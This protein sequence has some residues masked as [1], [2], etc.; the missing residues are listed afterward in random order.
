MPDFREYVRRNLPPLGLP[1]EREAEIVEE[2]ALEFEENFR[3]ATHSGLSPEEAFR[4]VVQRARPWSGLANELRLAFNAPRSKPERSTRT[5]FGGMMRDLRYG[6]RQLRKAPSFAI[7]TMLTLA[8]G[9]GANTAIFSLLDVVML[10]NLPVRDPQQLVLFGAGQARGGNDALPGGSTTLFS[11]PFFREFRR[12][13]QVFS[14]VAA[15]H[16]ILFEVHGRVGGSAGFEKTNVELVSGSYFHT[17]GV[18]SILGRVLTDADDQTP[19]AHPVAV[20]S[21][22]WWRQRFAGDPSILRRTI[23]VGP[24]IYTI[25]GVA[26][27][28]FFGMILEESPD[29]WIPLAMEKEISPGWNGL[30]QNLFQSLHI[31]ARRKPAVGMAQAGANSNL[32]F[33]QILREYA[34]PQP[35][36]SDLQ[37]IGRARIDLTSAA[38]GFSVLRAQFSRPLEI[39]MAVVALVLLIACANVAN[40]LLARG[41]ARYREIAVRLAMG[42][43]RS[44]LI[45]QLLVE[46]GLLGLAGA[47]LGILIAWGG[48]QLL[49]A[50]SPIR[51]APDARILAFTLALT[52][53]TVLLFGTFPA[54]RSTG[55]DLAPSLKEGRGVLSSPLR[56]RFSPSL[57]VGQVALSLVLLAG[58]GL[59]LR[60]FINLM[61]V[62]TGFDKRNLLQISI[63]PAAAGY[64]LDARLE[65][66]MQQVEDRVGSLPDIRGAS[67]AF[68][69]FGGSW[70]DHV[71]APGRPPS[72][73]DPETRHNVV[74]SQYFDAMKLPILAGRGFN[75]HDTMASRSVTV[76]NETM[77]KMYFPGASPLGRTFSITSATPDSA[78]PNV[79]VI[80]V[81]KNAKYESLREPPKP[82]AYYPH[83][84]HSERYLFNLLVRYDGKS[85]A[86]ASE[87][88]K[89][90]AEVDPNLPAGDVAAFA[91]AVDSWTQNQRL[92]A[93]LSSLFGILAAFLAAIGIYGV[94]SYAIARRTNEFGIRIAL[95]AQRR[96][97][98]WVVLRETLTLA[99]LGACAGLALALASGRLVESL[100]FDLKAHDPFA[101]G[102]AALA[103]VAVALLAGYLPARRATRIDPMAALRSE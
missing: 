60:S 34:G 20:A 97:V 32:L 70:T 75:A 13:N 74:G 90:I 71:A 68:T 100:L 81:V 7:I 41:A 28:G 51:V 4:E 5:V 43:K 6:A 48:T 65:A 103:I 69:T 31:V 94:M 86:V 67:F 44:Q 95:G 38:T 55:L 76:I 89:A 45:R 87:I 35:T 15:V 78:W 58:A 88:Q 3:R 18:N 37:R 62:D 85:E 52:I 82:A 30:E 24:T 83:S 1:G 26:P 9:V 21:Y 63:D 10:R 42:A 50:R 39:L 53:L 101:I 61:N 49:L 98:I 36:Q 23:S 14:D 33:K 99:L 73:A 72:E 102:E 57:I 8:L 93:V 84:Q 22:S 25:V 17:L 79:E 47:A 64:Q 19:G 91:D 54:F 16:S 92:V 80:G 77:A 59:F 40:L 11:Y 27:P 12:Q 46:S 66:M 29:L 2:L 96:H 56:G